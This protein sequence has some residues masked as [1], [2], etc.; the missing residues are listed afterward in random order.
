MFWVAMHRPE[1]FLL[2]PLE[3]REQGRLRRAAVD[4]FASI[5]GD[6]AHVG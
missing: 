1:G 6:L 5:V 2:A 4:A 3:S